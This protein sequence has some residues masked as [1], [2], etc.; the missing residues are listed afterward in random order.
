VWINAKALVCRNE[1]CILSYTDFG[2]MNF[3]F[4]I[5]KNK[6]RVIRNLYGGSSVLDF[7]KTTQAGTLFPIC[8]QSG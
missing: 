5:P 2:M 6:P 3:G 8:V 1:P 7:A 4:R